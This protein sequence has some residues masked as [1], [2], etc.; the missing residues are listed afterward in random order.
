MACGHFSDID[1]C[2]RQKA[3]PLIDQDKGRLPPRQAG[4]SQFRHAA[5]A[6]HP[7]RAVVLAARAA[8]HDWL[9][10][11]TGVG[12]SGT[13]LTLTPDGNKRLAA[14]VSLQ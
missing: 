11:L 5:S 13:V 7:A 2:R 9:R 12:L 4:A 3:W 1:R 14:A 6:A 10:R 8:V